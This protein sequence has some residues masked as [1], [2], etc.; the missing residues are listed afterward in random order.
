[1]LRRAATVC[2][3]FSVTRRDVHTPRS[4]GLR[5]LGAIFL[6]WLWASRCST[7]ASQRGEIIHVTAVQSLG[8]RANTRY[9]WEQRPKHLV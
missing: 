3:L 6:S 9:F 7:A 8:K 4:E 2:P 5:E 1:M